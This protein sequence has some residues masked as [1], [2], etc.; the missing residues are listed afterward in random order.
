MALQTRK[1]SHRVLAV[2]TV[3][4]LTAIGARLFAKAESPSVAAATS[5]TTVRT[6][7]RSAFY[8]ESM[9]RHATTQR[10][11]HL[12]V[13]DNREASKIFKARGRGHALVTGGAGFIGSHC[14]L[15]LLELGYAVTVIDNMSRGNAGAL[16]ALREQSALTG[17]FRVV[18]GDLGVKADIEMAFSNT[19]AP[20]DVVFHFAAIAYVGE[21]MSDPLRYYSNITMNTVNL[22][23]VMAARGAKSLIYSSTCATYGNPEKLPITE[24]TPTIPI[25]PYGKSKLYAENAIRDYAQAHPDFKATILRYFNVIGSDAKLRIGEFPRDNLRAHSRISGACFDAAMGTI[26]KLKLL[27]T[28]HPTRDGTTIRDFVHVTDLVDAHIAVAEKGNLVNPPSLYNIGTGR[29]VS[30]R[31][32]VEACKRVTASNIQVEVRHEPRPG[33]YAEVYASVDKIRKELGWEAKYTDLD[34][35]LSHSWAFRRKI[36]NNSWD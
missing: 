6:T 9:G 12:Q 2:A 15:K 7:N 27:G 26:P 19:I 14:A 36:A 25:N 33:D 21:S 23:E 24:A 29:G 22:L 11:V 20:V 34:Q 4:V 32:F 35:S 18:I 30:M 8:V 17:L 5:K 10:S 28:N 13:L 16:R 3:W 31:E 1:Y